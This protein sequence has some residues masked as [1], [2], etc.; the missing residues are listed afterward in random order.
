MAYEWTNHYAKLFCDFHL[1]GALDVQSNLPGIEVL[2]RAHQMKTGQLKR[3]S[4]VFTCV[5]K[6]SNHR[7]I[8][9]GDVL[10]T[11]RIALTKDG[12]QPVEADQWMEASQRWFANEEKWAAFIRTLSVADRTGWSISHKRIELNVETE[13]DD[14][15]HT[16]DITLRIAIRAIAKR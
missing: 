1:A 12:E 11:L 15:K 2:P 4:V 13:T 8:F 7:A 6:E 9:A 14:E 10:M 16:R 3:P 5:A